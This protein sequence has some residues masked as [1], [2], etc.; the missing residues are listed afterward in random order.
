MD[1]LSLSEKE[2]SDVSNMSVSDHFLFSMRSVGKET[3]APKDCCNFWGSFK[4]K[5]PP[6]IRDR[7]YVSDC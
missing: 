6:E 4:D 7:G 2:G 1:D 3:L 5:E